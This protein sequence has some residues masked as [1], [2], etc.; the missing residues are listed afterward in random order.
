MIGRIDGT[1]TL[2]LPLRLECQSLNGYVLDNLQE[3]EKLLASGLPYR[4]LVRATVAAGFP[5]ATWRSIESATY[6]ARRACPT[7]PTRH[8][9]QPIVLAAR[10]A[11][12]RETYSRPTE[13]ADV[14][15]TIGRRFRQLVRPPRPGS[16]EKDLL[17]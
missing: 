10:S 7:R 16:D 4:S 5:S 2:V 9:P 17:F 6:R 8:A 13:E 1:K 12:R 11:A 15:V 14:T 3:L